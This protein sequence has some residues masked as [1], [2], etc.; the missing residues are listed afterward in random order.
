MCQHP[1]FVGA[2]TLE[3]GSPEYCSVS[4]DIITGN[5]PYDVPKPQLLVAMNMNCKI[6]QTIERD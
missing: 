5:I 4:A 1:S 3:V 6:E 2:A